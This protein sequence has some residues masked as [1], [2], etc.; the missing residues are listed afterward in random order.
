MTLAARNLERW[1]VVEPRDAPPPELASFASNLYVALAPLSWL[2]EQVAWAL[3]NHCAAIGTMFQP[4]EDLVRDTPEGTG[5]SSVLDLQRC[6]D[7]WLPWLAQFV[8]VTL[9]A[10][11]TPDEQRE[12]ITRT[13]GFNRGTPDAIRAAAQ[14]TLSGNRTVYF[15]ER[16]GDP[17]ALEV[18]TITRETPDPAATLA[19]LIAQKPGGIVLR[20]RVVEGL[21]WQAVHDS[22]RTWRDVRTDYASWRDLREDVEA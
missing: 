20:Y 5:W 12:R 16:D 18:V 9:I 15:R 3:A 10:G 17:Y 2:D 22:G 11:S 1:L 19:A 6:P 4:I 7:A 8:G 21:D 14:A 13:D